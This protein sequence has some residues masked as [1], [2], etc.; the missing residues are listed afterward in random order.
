[1]ELILIKAVFIRKELLNELSKKVPIAKT[2]TQIKRLLKPE[3]PRLFSFEVFDVSSGRNK[4]QK[5]RKGKLHK[6]HSLL[7]TL[8]TLAILPHFS[9]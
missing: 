5:K 2:L 1:M 4:V 6:L 9:T 7:A 3:Q 8:K